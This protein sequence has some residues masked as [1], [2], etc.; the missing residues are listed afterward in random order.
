VAKTRVVEPLPL[1]G[2]GAEEWEVSGFSGGTPGRC[3]GESRGP[4]FE[5][6]DAG[7][8]AFSTPSFLSLRELCER[9]G[10]VGGVQK[11]RL[12]LRG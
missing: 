7:L 11:D 12:A 9:L 1:G 6:W 5:D 8:L 2:A 4:Q 10:K 3:F